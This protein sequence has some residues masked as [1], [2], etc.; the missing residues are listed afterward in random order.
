M[1]RAWKCAHRANARDSAPA[2]RIGTI[3]AASAIN[4]PSDS[5]RVA[6]RSW[7]EFLAR[8]CTQS[9]ATTTTATTAVNAR[10]RRGST[11]IRKPRFTS[12]KAEVRISEGTPSSTRAR[13]S[14]TDSKRLSTSPA[15]RSRKNFTGSSNVR[16]RS[17][18]DSVAS[19][20]SRRR[21]TMRF[22]AKNSTAA[23]RLA[24]ANSI[25][26][27]MALAVSPQGTAE[28]NSALVASGRSS[29]ANPPIK[30]NS[31][32]NQAE[33]RLARIDHATRANQ[34]PVA[35]RGR[36]ST[37]AST[38]GSGRSPATVR[39]RETAA[40]SSAFVPR[41]MTATGAL[42]TS[43]TAGPHRCVHHFRTGQGG[44]IISPDAVAMP[45][46]AVRS[47]STRGS[48]ATTS[49]E[50]VAA[51]TENASV[52]G[53]ASRWAVRA[54]ESDVP[55]AATMSA[56]R[57]SSSASA[58]NEFLEKS[59]G[60]DVLVAPTLNDTTGVDDE[61]LVGVAHGAQPVRDDQ[62]GTSAAA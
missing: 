40:I 16:A 22:R 1:V 7:R 3:A 25:R 31:T 8:I 48:G 12:P 29:P 43:T 9:E 33:R 26:I 6:R 58:M 10:P 47:R 42:G 59:V 62:T 18:G 36:V 27:A 52:N 37:I 45:S 50:A 2:T 28:V 5:L 60:L 53:S 15:E 39:R 19:E 41:G 24:T 17:P 56:A 49:W 21:T 32:R 35:G 30:A 55:A 51:A 54:L 13:A 23:P 46:A 57:L 44:E 14:S 4:I 34:D 61:D 11:A 38:G 20:M